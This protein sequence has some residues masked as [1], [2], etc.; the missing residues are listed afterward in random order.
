MKQNFSQRWK[1]HNHKKLKI[2][3]HVALSISARNSDGGDGV[4]F[5]HARKSDPE[6]KV[7]KVMQAV[8]ISKKA[9]NSAEDSKYQDR[10]L[11]ISMW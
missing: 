9:K 11:N 5:I 1:E 3:L 8:K 10:N 7:K 4:T 2:S 6:V